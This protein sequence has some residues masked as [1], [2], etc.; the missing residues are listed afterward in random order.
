MK[1]LCTFSQSNSFTAGKQYES[2]V[3]RRCG[4][5]FHEVIGNH[6]FPIALQPGEGLGFISAYSG[7]KLMADF[8]PVEE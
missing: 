3:M 8:K 7:H 4:M 6:G 5:D 2:R 1:L